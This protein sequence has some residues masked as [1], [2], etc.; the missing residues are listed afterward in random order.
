VAFSFANGLAQIQTEDYKNGY[1]DKSGRVVFWEDRLKEDFS[2]NLALFKTHGNMPD[3]KSGY[4]DM[5]G[6]QAVAPIF[7]WGQSFAEGLAC[8]SSDKKAGFIDTKGNV[9]IPLRFDSCRSFS[10]GFAAVMIGGKWGYINKSGKVIIEARFADAEQFSDG[11][12]VV[13]VLDDSDVPRDEQ[14]YKSGDN[15]ISVMPGKFG[16]V[17]RT[18]QMVLPTRFVQLG[19]F[20]HGLAW[21]NL[22]NDYIVHGDT[23]KWGY[24]NKAGKLVWTSRKARQKKSL[25]AIGG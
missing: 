21:V 5:T 25:D 4:L 7:D 11:V 23:D 13:R 16:A 24:I 17:D 18:G 2:D 20:S 22:G 8:V 6:H 3:S 10:E 9:A 1:V 14:R 12:A 15:I 19:N